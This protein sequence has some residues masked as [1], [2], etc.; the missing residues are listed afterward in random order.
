MASELIGYVGEGVG[1]GAGK[2]GG[3]R[4]WSWREAWIWWW[5]WRWGLKWGAPLQNISSIFHLPLRAITHCIYL[6][7]SLHKKKKKKQDTAL[8]QLN[9]QLLIPPL[10]STALLSCT[11]L[12]L[13]WGEVK[14][15][16]PANKANASIWPAASS[17]PKTKIASW[18]QVASN[19]WRHLIISPSLA[20]LHPH[21]PRSPD[22]LLLLKINL[23]LYA[24][25]TRVREETSWWWITSIHAKTRSFRIPGT[26]PV[27]L[28]PPSHSIST[29][30]MVDE[31]LERQAD[32]QTDG[33]AGRNK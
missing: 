18:P 20:N 7:H 5:W 1:K 8:L 13:P 4:S 22:L 32:S 12:Y 19:H 16:I 9:M 25:K 28:L 31:G 33:V 26:G 29:R 6:S 14:M 24:D 23:L 15:K 21:P 27:Y 17:E 30:V 10:V 11:F 3:L 2:G